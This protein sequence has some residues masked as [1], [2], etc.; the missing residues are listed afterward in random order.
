MT[1][2]NALNAAIIKWL[3]YQG[4]VAWRNNNVAV[5]DPKIKRYRK[6][7]GERGVGDIMGYTI[8]GRHLEVETKVGRDELSQDQKNHLQSLLSRNCISIVTKDFDDF[9]EQAERYGLERR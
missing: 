7:I 1:Q 9:L 3:C 4:H 6:F 2:T 5:Y 8:E